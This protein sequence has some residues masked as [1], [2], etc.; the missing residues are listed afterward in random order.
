MFWGGLGAWPENPLSQRLTSVRYPILSIPRRNWQNDRCGAQR[1]LWKGL[2][3]V[4]TAPCLS[5]HPL[6]LWLP[7]V[8]VAPC[9][10]Y[11]PS[12]LS[13]P[14]RSL[15]EGTS[16]SFQALALVLTTIVVDHPPHRPTVTIV[17]SLPHR[18]T[19]TIVVSHNDRHGVLSQSEG[20]APH[21]INRNIRV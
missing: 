1:S 19:E 13:L 21:S 8:F 12:L 2:K 16:L 5:S 15:W 10:L 9:C 14:Q 6:S 7:L 17:V 18:P 20:A 4:F 11:S 3:I